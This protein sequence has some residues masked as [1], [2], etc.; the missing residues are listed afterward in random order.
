MG[1]GEDGEW[2]GWG[3]GRMGSG[4]DGE[5]VGWGGWGVGRVVSSLASQTYFQLTGSARGESYCR[6]H[7]S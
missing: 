4:E 5:W 6:G 7:V 3:V 1:S 2:V